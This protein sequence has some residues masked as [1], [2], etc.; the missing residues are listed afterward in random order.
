MSTEEKLRVV[1]FGTP[2]FVIPVLELLYESENLLGVV[3]QPDKPR[4]RGLKPLPSPVKSWALSKGLPVFE[5]QKLRDE[6]FLRILRELNLD[7]IV[8]FAY[9]KILPK[10]VLEIP[11]AGCWN[12]HLSLLPRHR[13]A[14]P[15]QWAIL[16]GD[17]VTGVTI[18]LMDEG[19]DTGPILLQKE[20][21]IEEADTTS[22]L[23]PKLVE[24]SVSA[25]KETLNLY[26][27]GRLSP[28]P[29]PEEGISFA[30]LI[31]K[32]DGYTDFNESADRVVR[33]LKAFV[34][35]PGVFT[36]FRG[37]ILKLHSA[38]KRALTV[39]SEPGT[40]LEINK[41]GIL[42]ATSEGALLIKELQLEGK[43]K[44]SAFDFALGQRLQP[45]QKLQ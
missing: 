16:E 22:T 27:E 1:F 35:W 7:L 11:K 26:K 5:P 40:I 15:V 28:R 12:I 45:G 10:E 44:V 41:E 38:E 33:K 43:K 30:P 18:M 13:G 14:S 24:L 31:R 8:V 21:A 3:T 19:M 2:D 23:L 25:L 32:E 29:Q 42:V 39:S 20:L 36:Y 37:K 4:G 9:G 6:K 17:K 34:P